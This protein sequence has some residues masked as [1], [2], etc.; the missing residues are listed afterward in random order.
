MLS[1]V[2]V[3]AP[4]IGPPIAKLCLFDAPGTLIPNFFKVSSMYV[5]LL[6]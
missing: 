5:E 6:I 2:A 3:P 4:S 1:D